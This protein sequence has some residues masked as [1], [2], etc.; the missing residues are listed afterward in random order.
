MAQVLLM[1]LV[2][3]VAGQMVE[4]EVLVLPEEMH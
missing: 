2:E 4:L 3:M 1:V